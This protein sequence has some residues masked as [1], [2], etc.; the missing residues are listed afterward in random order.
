MKTASLL[1]ETRGLLYR[2]HLKARK[3]L[4]QHFLI[5]E[6]VLKVI[7]SAAELTPADVVVEV[8]PGL[9]VLSRELVRQAGWVVAVEL[10]NQLAVLLKMSN[11]A[12]SLLSRI[13]PFR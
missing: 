7:T 9:G 13:S 3:G 11:S 5:D 8:G 6:E 4:G 12:H 1:A 10:D 2:F